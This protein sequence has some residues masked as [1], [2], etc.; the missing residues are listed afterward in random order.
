MYAGAEASAAAENTA[1]SAGASVFVGVEAAA[2][3]ENTAP[4]AGASVH[5][6]V[7]TAVAAENT[8]PSAGA[9]VHEGVEAAAAA[10]LLAATVPVGEQP[11]PAAGMAA[12]RLQL[13]LATLVQYCTS[14]RTFVACEAG[15]WYWQP[16][17]Q[18]LSAYLHGGGVAKGGRIDESE[19]KLSAAIDG[20]WSASTYG[21]KGMHVKSCL[22]CLSSRLSVMFPS[23]GGWCCVW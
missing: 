3:A 15:W 23:L 11:R 13:L 20:K 14:R 22:L 17:F 6:G 2:A 18:Q 16:G 8:A 1:P 10:V 9:S 4:S 12:H 19:E 7:E 5:V 21:G